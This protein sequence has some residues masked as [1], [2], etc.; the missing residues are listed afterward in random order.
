MAIEL[1]RQQ[2]TSTLSDNTSNSVNQLDSKQPVNVIV[3]STSHTL[4]PKKAQNSVIINK[5]PENTKSDENIDKTDEN[6]CTIPKSIIKS[7]S[8]KLSSSYSNKTSKS[9]VLS[10]NK[11]ASQSNEN[12]SNLSILRSQ[13]NLGKEQENRQNKKS[14]SRLF[15]S[16]DCE[17]ENGHD[18]AGEQKLI[19]NSKKNNQ[20]SAKNTETEVS[21]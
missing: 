6:S 16:L 7:S 20:K 11:Y 3:K 19:E 18:N 8:M 15:Y 1:S 17:V 14:E 12:S 5:K 13:M 21:F 9:V 2:P 4:S 10:T